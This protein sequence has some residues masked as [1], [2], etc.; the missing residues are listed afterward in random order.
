MGSTCSTSSSRAGGCKDHSLVASD[1]SV[2]FTSA[3]PPMR[4]QPQLRGQAV[5][6]WSG[7][8]VTPRLENEDAA[9]PPQLDWG[10]LNAAQPNSLERSPAQAAFE[11]V[12]RW[13]GT[14]EQVHPNH[15][16]EGASGD[17]PVFKT[18][19]SARSDFSD[20][21]TIA[22]EKVPNNDACSER[23]AATIEV[24]AALREC[25]GACSCVLGT[26]SCVGQHGDA[27][28]RRQSS[29]MLLAFASVE[30]WGRSAG[31]NG[32]D[33]YGAGYHTRVEVVCDM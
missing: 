20:A 16:A 29:A 14:G 31:E 4:G 9:S 8:R 26:C 32:T 19:A 33:H 12:R 3:A 1:A 5:K 25:A 24:E 22:L 18:T 2:V 21:S 10:R 11:R 28:R 15:A 23:T 17:R 13:S 6:P 30:D 7:S 27:P